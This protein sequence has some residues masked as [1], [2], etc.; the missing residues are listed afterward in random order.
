[1]NCPVCKNELDAV[2][3]VPTVWQ[4][5]HCTQEKVIEHSRHP[6]VRFVGDTVATLKAV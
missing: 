2:G 4:C 6:E 5:P 3:G 1:M